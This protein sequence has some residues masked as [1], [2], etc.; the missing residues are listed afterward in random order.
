MFRAAGA[1]RFSGSR[2]SWNRPHR[3][4]Q[5]TAP[6]EPAAVHHTAHRLSILPEPVPLNSS[7]LFAWILVA[8]EDTGKH[9][10]ASGFE[11]S[12]CQPRARTGQ[13]TQTSRDSQ[14][15]RRPDTTSVTS[16]D[17]RVK[18]PCKRTAVQERASSLRRGA[19]PLRARSSGDKRYRT[20]KTG[21]RQNRH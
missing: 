9:M 17:P 6:G 16:V 18:R 14:T 20:R 4:S 10:C 15:T 8:D 11:A 19:V 1:D 7:A 5:P 21:Q 13:K 12:L 3:S 2:S